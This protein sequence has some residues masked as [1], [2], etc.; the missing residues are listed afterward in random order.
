MFPSRSPIIAPKISHF[1]C[2]CGRQ[3]KDYQC[4]QNVHHLHPRITTSSIPH[5]EL[6][7]FIIQGEA[8]SSTLPSGKFLIQPFSL[9]LSFSHC[10][11]VIHSNGSWNVIAPFP[12]SLSLTI[13]KSMTPPPHPFH[14]FSIIQ[15]KYDRFLFHGSIPRTQQATKNSYKRENAFHIQSIEH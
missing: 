4:L 3:G 13:R 2:I 14:I 10:Y 9:S 5:K 12:F 1:S 8:H 6:P 11:C 7:R 15:T